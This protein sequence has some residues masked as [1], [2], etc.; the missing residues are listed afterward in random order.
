LDIGKFCP[1]CKYKNEQE[2]VICARCGAYLE[3]ISGT[4]LT[5]KA[6]EMPMSDTGKVEALLF[7]KA[8]IPVDGIA[9]YIDGTSKPV[10]SSSDKEFVIG[11]KVKENW[12]AL[13]DLSKFGGYQLGL[14]RRHVTI[15]RTDLG[16][17]VIDFSTN[18]TWLNGERLMPHKPYPLANGSQLQLA[19]MRFVVMYRPVAESKQKA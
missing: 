14:S 7:D 15:R 10:F 13:I 19:R 5:T 1:V 8:L 9:F 4:A 17:E 12:E 6:I 16:Y 3:P 2:A 11:R 18:G